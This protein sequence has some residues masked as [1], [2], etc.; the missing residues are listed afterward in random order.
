MSMQNTVGLIC[1]RQSRDICMS[2]HS[3]LSCLAHSN[4]G[5]SLPCCRY[6]Y[7]EGQFWDL[8]PL[9]PQFQ[10]I[11]SFLSLLLVVLL[12]TSLWEV[13]DCFKVFSSASIPS[14][15]L[16]NSFSGFSWRLLVVTA[17]VSRSQLSYFQRMKFPLAFLVGDMNPSL[18]SDEL[19]HLLSLA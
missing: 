9:V 5:F 13:L 8:W 16:I 18:V 12:L 15:R 2:L 14:N 3:T 7:G 1:D 19:H 6:F 10:Q 17:M 4:E 11:R